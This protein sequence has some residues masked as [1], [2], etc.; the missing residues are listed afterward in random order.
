MRHSCSTSY[1][2]L[3]SVRRRDVTQKGV[4]TRHDHALWLVV[5]R[6]L[7][8]QGIRIFHVTALAGSITTIDLYPVEPCTQDSGI[9]DTLSIHILVHANL[10]RKFVHLVSARSKAGF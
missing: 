4:E 1:G 6:R 5:E 9:P 10:S 2:P 3:L 8:I 7:T